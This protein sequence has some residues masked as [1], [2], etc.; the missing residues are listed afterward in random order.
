[1]ISPNQQSKKKNKKKKKKA[2]VAVEEDTDEE[3]ETGTK[4]A[5]KKGRKGGNKPEEMD[6]VDKALAELDIKW[7]KRLLMETMLTVQIWYIYG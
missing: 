3:E 2:P 7:V 6:E 1:V 5:P 4:P